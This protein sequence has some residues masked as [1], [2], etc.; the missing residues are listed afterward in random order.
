MAVYRELRAA[1]DE[2]LAPANLHRI[3]RI[4]AA[5]IRSPEVGYPIVPFTIQAIAAALSS[6]WSQQ[7]VDEN[8]AEAVDQEL[9]PRVRELLGS[10]EQPLNPDEL[11]RRLDAVVCAYA[12]CFE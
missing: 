11:A 10:V 6:H 2:G 9:L 8:E 3:I 7:T 12:R 1:L 4:S 5:L